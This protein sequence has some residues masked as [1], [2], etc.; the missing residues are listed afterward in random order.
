MKKIFA[1]IVMVL[2]MAG[3]VFALSDAEY[4]TLK[5][6]NTDFARADNRLTQVYGKLKATLSEK[7]FAEIKDEQLEWI[8]SGRDHEARALMNGGYSRAEA[9]TMATSDRADY[10][11]KI[12]DKA[13][14]KAKKAKPKKPGKK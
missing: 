11:Q 12:L 4:L 14:A 13:Q 9:Y 7:K 6:S 1:A 8:E 3:S 2:V 5:K 10:L